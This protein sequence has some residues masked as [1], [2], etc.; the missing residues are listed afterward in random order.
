VK[1][2]GR[3]KKGEEGRGKERDP[4]HK[5]LDPPPDLNIKQNYMEL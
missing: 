4:L 1:R 3:G 5:F 2:K